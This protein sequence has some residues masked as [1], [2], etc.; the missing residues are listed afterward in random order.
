MRSHVAILLRLRWKLLFASF[1]P[2][3]GR[4]VAAVLGFVMVAV[5]AGFFAV[6]SYLVLRQAEGW[7]PETQSLARPAILRLVFLLT[8]LLQLTTG[9]AFL[10]VSDFFDTTRLL[11]LP[12]RARSIFLAMLWSSVLSP[13]TLVFG[14][15][16]IGAMCALSGGPADQAVRL[17]AVLG[18]VVFGQAC[19]LCIGYLLLQ[20]LNRRRLRDLATILGSALGVGSYLVIRF[21][22]RPEVIRG[23][24]ASGP[25]A[26][27]LEL[28]PT[29]WFAELVAHEGPGW[30][31][32]RAIVAG[33]GSLAASLL[34]GAW[35]FSRF[36]VR[37]GESGD[38]DRTTH[39]APRQP[40]LFSS[41]LGAL[42]RQ[43][44]AIIWREP[45][46]KAML[47]QQ[48]IFLLIPMVSLSSGRSIGTASWSVPFFI[49]FSHAW[50]ALSM[51]GIDGPGLR[52]LL[53][54]PA[55]RAQILLGRVL[56]VGRLFAIID[57]AA[58]A[59]MTAVM[60]VV[61]GLADP[62]R[63]F[64]E[65]SLICLVADGIMVGAG[66]FI[67]VV[68]PFP[69]VR[70]S[71]AHRM[72]QEGCATSAG[73]AVLRL[74]VMFFAIAI[75]FLATLPAFTRRIDSYW[76]L[77]TIPAGLLVVLQVGGIALNRGARRLAANEERILAA[78]TDPGD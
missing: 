66:A 76:Y 15:P 77:A 43:S 36:Y 24:A 61:S 30:P 65:M 49:V 11:H 70:R 68:A 26:K 74:P 72:K 10:S 47:F 53:Q 20:A 25:L 2:H 22:M 13:S 16:A 5:W 34:L 64:A 71:R 39:A 44:T 78:L 17:A 3:S 67:S 14:A 40:T 28:F 27:A 62:F 32:I 50:M 75:G 38:S 46:L 51:L 42:V 69:L 21:I 31:P 6:F 58:V 59:A 48:M 73:R 9:V 54:S 1:A 52:L 4:K 29:S 37:A 12:I 7:S 56:A 19:A 45:Q 8:F 35:S 18:L 23:W 55:P 41:G 63:R 60:T 57:V 33:G